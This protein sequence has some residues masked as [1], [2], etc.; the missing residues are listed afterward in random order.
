DDGRAE[1]LDRPGD[2][3]GRL[4][5]RPGE[6]HYL[7]PPAGGGLPA[8]RA[9]LCHPGQLV[10]PQAPGGAGGAPAVAAD[11]AGVAAD[12]CAVAECDREAVA[13]AEA[14][15]LEVAPAGRGLAGGARPGAAVPGPV[16]ARLAAAAGVRGLARQRSVG[17]D[18]SWPM[19]TDLGRQNSSEA[20]EGAAA[21][22]EPD[23]AGQPAS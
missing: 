22:P 9:D 14:G 3:R 10:D 2:V 7:L 11:R 17:A 16:R 8:G 18:D 15:R 5:R 12:V 13:L 19:I 6:G 1:C 21:T 4:H 20:P 23:T